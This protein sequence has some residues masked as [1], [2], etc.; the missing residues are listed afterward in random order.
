MRLF[1][2]RFVQVNLGKQVFNSTL[3]RNY[4]LYILVFEVVVFTIFM[5]GVQKQ[6]YSTPYSD[7]K[8]K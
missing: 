4:F 5:F 8:D 2:T 3:L 6:K 1:L 7:N